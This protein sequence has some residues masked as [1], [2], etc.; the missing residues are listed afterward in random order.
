MAQEL[1]KAIDETTPKNL[2][3]NQVFQVNNIIKQNQLNTITQE[4]NFS[5]TQTFDNRN[6]ANV[7]AIDI[8]DDDL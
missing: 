7:G 1:V 6:V 5:M 3:E 2:T 8:I 4:D